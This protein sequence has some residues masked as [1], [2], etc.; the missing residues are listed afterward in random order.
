MEMRRLTPITVAVPI[1][2]P[3][4]REQEKY[5]EPLQ[6]DAGNSIPHFRNRMFVCLLAIA[7]NWFTTLSIAKNFSTRAIDVPS[8]DFATSTCKAAYNITKDERTSHSVC[9][10]TQLNQCNIML[11][12]TTKKE[13]KRVKKLSKYN[14]DVVRRIEEVATNCSNSYTTLRLA[15]EDWTANG[16]EIPLRTEST[17][18]ESTDHICSAEDQ[19][20]F[21]QTMLGTQNTLALQTEALQMATAYSDESTM[22]VT[23]LASTVTDLDNDRSSLNDY[24]ED[25]V[26]YD[27]DYLDRKMQNIRDGVYGVVKSLDPALIPV[28]D[29]DDIFQ[30][31]GISA[32]DVMACVS[33]DVNARMVNG[34]VCQP[35]LAKMVDDFVVDAKWKVQFLTQKLYDYRDKAN[36][37]KQNVADT[38]VVTKRFYDGKIVSTLSYLFRTLFASN[39]DYLNHVL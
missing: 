24:I 34:S 12:Q 25:R 20:L 36:E 38:Y 2:P 21:N 13:D 18:T 33:L 6:K 30:D 8:F 10:E 27:I 17:T 1:I 9:V 35:N 7:A 28:V 32:K 11:D 37:Y 4:S 14:E 15:M 3:F 23:R 29:L 39:T 19:A 22:T 5:K 26:K 16:G 31:V